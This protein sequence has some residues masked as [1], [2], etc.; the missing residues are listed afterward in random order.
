MEVGWVVGDKL[1]VATA[2][3]REAAGMAAARAAARVAAGM[4]AV[5]KEHGFAQPRHLRRPPPRSLRGPKR[6]RREE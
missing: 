4:A 5:A 6:A 1:V 2:E 3:E